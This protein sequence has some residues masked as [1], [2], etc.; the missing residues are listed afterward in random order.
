[1]VRLILLVVINLWIK[2]NPFSDSLPCI[3]CVIPG[4]CGYVIE[5]VSYTKHGSYTIW[6]TPFIKNSSSS[7]MYIQLSSILNNTLQSSNKSKIFRLV[8][9]FDTRIDIWY[10]GDL[11]LLIS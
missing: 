2:L 9:S 10:E 8:L 3:D 1:M 4:I 11:L 7:L 5:I 6:G